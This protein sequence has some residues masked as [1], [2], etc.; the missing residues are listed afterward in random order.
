L[1]AADRVPQ[2]DDPAPGAGGEGPVG[3]ERQRDRLIGAER[4]KRLPDL[5]GGGV[6]DH[7][8]AIRA[9]CGQELPVAGERESAGETGA[10]PEILRHHELTVARPPDRQRR[11]VI[12]VER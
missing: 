8:A 6:K 1:I 12:A 11:E 4:A 10:G 2:L 5:T 9:A 7:H 3:G